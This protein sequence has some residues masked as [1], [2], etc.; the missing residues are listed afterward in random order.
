MHLFVQYV[1]ASLSNKI[2]LMFP[3]SVLQLNLLS[4]Q[5]RRQVDWYLC[6]EWDLE[7]SVKGSLGIYL[8][9]VK[10][11]SLVCI[12][13]WS[14]SFQVEEKCRRFN[15]HPKRKRVAGLFSFNLNLLSQG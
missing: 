2:C 4:A 9:V 15:L 13:L 3:A 7:F 6:Y 11:S 14:Q 1:L 8:F 12:C 10:D 5:S